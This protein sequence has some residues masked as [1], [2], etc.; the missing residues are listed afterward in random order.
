MRIEIE[1]GIE[2]EIEQRR[3]RLLFVISLPF[4]NHHFCRVTTKRSLLRK[5]AKKGDSNHLF[6]G[7]S[8]WAS[9]ASRSRIN[10]C[11]PPFLQLR[12]K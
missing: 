3:D 9:L 6:V 7:H 1:I 5:Y 8:E 12:V 11:C 4:S 10:G 2:I